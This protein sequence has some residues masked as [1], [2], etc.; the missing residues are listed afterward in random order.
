MPTWWDIS[1]LQI[2]RETR[3]K[4]VNLSRLPPAKKR[5]AWRKI[6]EQQPELAALLQSDEVQ[7]MI[8]VFDAEVWVDE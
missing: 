2:V 6:K 1:H 3:Q 5:E 8:R 7:E 4:R